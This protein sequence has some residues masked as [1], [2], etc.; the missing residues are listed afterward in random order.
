VATAIVR[1]FNGVDIPIHPKNEYFNLTAMCK[2]EGK[3]WANY[4]AAE[5]FQEYVA[6]LSAFIGI[7]INDLIVSKRGDP[8]HGGGTWG[9]PRVASYL[10]QRL[11]AKFAVVVSGWIED[12]RKTGTASVDASRYPRSVG[13]WIP[14][15]ERCLHDHHL[16]ITR[17]F[18]P[19]SW[20]VVLEAVWFMLRFQDRL[21]DHGLVCTSRD[22]MDGSIGQCYAIWRASQPWARPLPPSHFIKVLS[23]QGREIDVTVYPPEEKVYFHQWL[24]DV[25]HPEKLAPYVRRK[26]KPTKGDTGTVGRQIPAVS[27]ARLQSILVSGK[28]STDLRLYEQAAIDRAPEGVIRVGDPLALPAPRRRML[29]AQSTPDLFGNPECY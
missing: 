9:H 8:A 5:G 14:R 10:A 6:E 28:P 26:F 11:S 1:K 19:S 24:R 13:G 12:L 15:L 22:L 3:L 16:Y 4:W 17:K 29:E 27:A 7:P 23:E 20:T 2:A 25:Y 18:T 21:E